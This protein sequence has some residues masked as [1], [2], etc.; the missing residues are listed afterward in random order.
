MVNIDDKNRRLTYAD[1]F[2]VHLKISVLDVGTL[3]NHTMVQQYIGSACS[4]WKV[5]EKAQVAN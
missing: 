3:S 2:I 5:K 4:V 1:T